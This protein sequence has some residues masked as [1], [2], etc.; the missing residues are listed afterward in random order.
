MRARKDE[1][2]EVLINLIEN[3]RDAEAKRVTVALKPGAIVVR[4]DGRGIPRD[5]LPRIFEP[6]FSTTTSGTGLGLAI[7]KRLVEGWG[8]AIAVESRGGGGTTVTLR[9][10][11]SEEIV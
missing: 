8:G 6:Q 2:R 5:N 3:A 9:F 4:D 10:L 7:C 1:L 11:G